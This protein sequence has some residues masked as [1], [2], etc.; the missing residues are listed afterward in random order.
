MRQ[1]ALELGRD[2]IRVNGV[3]AD[4]VRSGIVTDEFIA[5]RAETRG[6]DEVAYMSGNLSKAGG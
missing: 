5:S 2:H 6:I 4:R 3:N 1:L